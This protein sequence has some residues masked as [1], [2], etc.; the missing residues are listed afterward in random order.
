MTN[1][2]NLGEA[3]PQ[4]STT[5]AQ[6][7]SHAQTATPLLEVKCLTTDFM[8]DKGT[9][10]AV[11]SVSFHIN[12]SETVGLV[13]E[14]GS[15]KSATAL[16]IMRLIRPPG[17]ITAGEI[18]YKGQDLL[19]LSPR[20]MQEIRGKEIAM[21][22][23]EPMS[24]LNPVFTI[25]DQIAEVVQ[26]HEGMSRRQ[27]MNRAAE[28]LSIV[29]I[30]SPERRLREYPHQLSGGMRQRVMIAIALSCTPK[31]L[32]ADEPTTA[33]D[34]TIQAQILDLLKELKSQF[35]MA[36]LLITH[37]LGVVA[38]TAQR[39]IVM[40]A[41]N[42]VEEAPVD[43]LFETPLHPYTQGLLRSVPR[44]DL[45][46]GKRRRLAQI[47]GTVPT[48]SGEL[49]PCCRFAPRCEFAKPSH[50]ENKPHLKEVRPRHKTACF[51]Y[52]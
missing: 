43:E 41:A 7:S 11:D 40:Y 18:F 34:V 4:F 44:I 21:I 32:I 35:G 16:S 12:P 13:G 42:I 37:D 50:F 19:T 27:A 1:N 8:S 23:Q 15:G 26:V 52:D 45:V 51:L 30:P 31:L 17:C 24:S 48:L 39:G 38:E 9:V 5:A 28:L 14:S 33:L 25:G 46:A 20:E 29:H 36:V 22:F 47:P 49:R 6:A 3:G 10:H 2:E